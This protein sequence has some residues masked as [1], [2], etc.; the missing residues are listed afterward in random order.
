MKCDKCGNDLK[1]FLFNVEGQPCWGDTCET[2][3]N[4]QHFRPAYGY[5]FM[6]SVSQEEFAEMY[7]KE[8]TH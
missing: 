6:K 3:Q 7:E 2:C 4:V 5:V 1:E 8:T